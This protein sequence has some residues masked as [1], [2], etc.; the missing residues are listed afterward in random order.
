MTEDLELAARIVTDLSWLIVDAG[1]IDSRNFMLPR[2]PEDPA[3]RA[4]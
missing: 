1:T 2:T 4:A 3:D